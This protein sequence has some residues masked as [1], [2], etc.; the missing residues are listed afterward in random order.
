MRDN[1]PARST[2]CND[3]YIYSACMCSRYPG[4]HDKDKTAWAQKIHGCAILVI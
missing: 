4:C 2:A 3:I 1:L